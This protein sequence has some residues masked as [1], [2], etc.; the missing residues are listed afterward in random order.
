MTAYLA[1]DFETANEQRASACAVGVVRVEDGDVAACWD[2]LIDPQAPFAPMNVMIHGI[3]EDAVAGAPT[4][5]EILD[6]LLKFA[7]GAE[8]VVAHNASF[9]VQVLTASIARYGLDLEPL[10]FACT[11]VFARRWWP[12]WPSYGLAPVVRRL[13]LD[14]VL[15]EWGHHDALW[16]ARACAAIA[17]RGFADHGVTTWG[18]AAESAQIRLGVSHIGGHDGC[19]SPHSARIEA[20][21]P[22]EEN[23]DPA[24]PLYGCSVCFTGALQLYTRRVAAQ[25]VADVGGYFS[26]NVT[27]TTDLLV[28]GI[29]DL[30][31]IGQDGMSSKMRKA[32]EMAAS[33]HHI[34]VLDEADFYQLLSAGG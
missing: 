4:F 9:D 5:P 31:R 28:V 23:L 11:R 29:Q 7:E 6:R 30:D 27:K 17:A 3:D 13:A 32:V 20:V 1:V 10:R 18:Q 15:G 26:P 33:G 19:V 21:R 25:T 16:D 14:E 34:E 2:T 22:H 24:H 12:A 8:V